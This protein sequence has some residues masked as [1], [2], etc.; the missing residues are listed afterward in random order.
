MTKAISINYLNLRAR[1]KIRGLRNTQKR[2]VSKVNSWD[3]DIAS[4]RQWQYDLWNITIEA[5]DVKLELG[6]SFNCG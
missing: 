2:L 6:D 4:Y 3:V 5:N 1:Y